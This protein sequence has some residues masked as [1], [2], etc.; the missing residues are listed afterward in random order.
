MFTFSS[1]PDAV[2]GVGTSDRCLIDSL[3]PGGK[4]KQ[5]LGPFDSCGK[6]R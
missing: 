1:V 4:S 3:L 6:G 2:L 5:V